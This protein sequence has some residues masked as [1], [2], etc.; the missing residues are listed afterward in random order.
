MK[1]RP[2]LFIIL[3]VNTFST[4]GA[5]DWK[6]NLLTARARSG[7][8]V[9]TLLKRYGLSGYSCNIDF[10][11]D[12]NNVT[13]RDRLQS[14]ERYKLPICVAAYNG[15]SIMST[16]EIDDWRKAERIKA[17]NNKA[18]DQGLR[19]ESFID[20]RKL[21]IPIHEL[22]CE[23][24]NAGETSSTT[25]V[26]SSA[27]RGLHGELSL[28]KGSRKFSIF[29]ETYANTPLVDQKLRNKVFYL[30]SG[31][32]GPDVGAQGQRGSHTLCEDEYAYDVT[33]R[34]MKKLL[35]H[36]ATVYMV[37]RDPDDGIRD[38]MFLECDKDEI[39][40]NNLEIPL[41]QRER[42]LQ[43]TEFINKMTAKHLNAGITD[44]TVIEIHIDSRSVHQHI[45]VF[46]YYKE[47]NEASKKLAN[48]MQTVFREKYQDR[49]DR[50]EY[51]GTV[52]TR[53]LHTLKDAKTRR[54]VYI[55]LAN[56]QNAGDQQRLI[57]KNNRQA[58][59]NWLYEGI[60]RN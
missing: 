33:L 52:T 54:A 58:I 59:A 46:F 2:L 19:P 6:D 24:D 7:D 55:E 42:L 12:R 4:L 22:E 53:S 39:V 29:G 14:N 40:W 5:Q 57:Q 47:G 26:S 17:F 48:N 31:H 15:R 8:N 45:D 32:G 18:L 34:L 56:I 27:I 1:N 30:I 43:R 9:L 44:Q 41:P 36:G 20:N 35:S 13:Q 21:W 10:F 37:V 28:S 25:S 11:C 23:S 50:R 3:A 49:P 60:I 51:E 16:I 38:N